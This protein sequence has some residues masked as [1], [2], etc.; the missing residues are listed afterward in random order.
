MPK[1]VS[2]VRRKRVFLSF[3]V[4]SITLCLTYISLSIYWG[5]KTFFYHKLD[6]LFRIFAYI[7]VAVYCFDTTLLVLTIRML[8]RAKVTSTDTGHLK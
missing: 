3:T 4:L 6:L 2:R 7:T 1:E 5:I 8:K